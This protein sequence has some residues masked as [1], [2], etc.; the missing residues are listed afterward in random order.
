MFPCYSIN[1]PY[2]HVWNTAVMSGPMLLVSTKSCLISYKNGYAGLLF[3]HLLPLLN[4]WLIVQ[5]YPVSCIGITS[6]SVHLNCLN[7]FHFL[8]HDGGLLVH[9]T[10]C[11]ISLSPF[12]NVATMSN[13]FFTCTARLWNSLPIVC[14]PLT[15]ILVAFSLEMTFFNLRFLLNRFP[16][17][18]AIFLY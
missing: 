16:L 10:D 2:G 9:L 8:I 1:L 5:M 7:W 13:S 4:H 6:V 14:F 12:L 18:F 17:L 3:L 11:M 15:M